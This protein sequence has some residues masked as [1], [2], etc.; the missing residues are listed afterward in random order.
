M[1]YIYIYIYLSLCLSLS[2]LSR[3]EE[4]ANVHV[5]HSDLTWL[6]LSHTPKLFFMNAHLKG[7]DELLGYLGY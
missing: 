4:P 1:D 5:K 3:T 2:V 6:S 7:F